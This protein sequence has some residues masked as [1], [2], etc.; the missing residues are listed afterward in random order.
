MPWISTLAGPHDELFRSAY[1]SCFA[2]L[3]LSIPGTNRIDRV[4]VL[5]TTA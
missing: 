1:S 2:A 5:A 4:D 3:L